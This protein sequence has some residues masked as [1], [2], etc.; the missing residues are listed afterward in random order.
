MTSPE[1]SALIEEN[2]A[3]REALKKAFNYVGVVPHGNSWAVR[4]EIE[5]TLDIT[6]SRFAELAALK[7]NVIG[8]AESISAYSSI[9]KDYNWSFIDTGLLQELIE[10]IAALREAQKR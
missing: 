4:E 7:E 10:S 2:R 3:L 9:R 5:D 6:R 8:K 1:L